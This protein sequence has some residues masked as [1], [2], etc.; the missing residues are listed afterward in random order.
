VR[1]VAT[2]LEGVPDCEVPGGV[3]ALLPQPDHSLHD[4]LRG[5]EPIVVV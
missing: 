3:E 5:V 1:L 4:E 2:Y